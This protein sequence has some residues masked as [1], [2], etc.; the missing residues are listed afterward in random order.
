MMKNLLIQHGLILLL[1]FSGIASRPCL[2]A[3]EQTISLDAITELPTSLSAKA[4]ADRVFTWWLPE[5]FEVLT[6]P[7]SGGLQIDMKNDNATQWLRSQSHWDLKELPLLG[8]RYGT[9]TLAIFVPWPVYASLVTD[10]KV[11]IRFAF[12]I[13]RNNATPCQIIVQWT[14]NRP[15]AVANRFREW[16]AA[17]PDIGM[18]PRPKPLTVKAESTTAVNQLFG[19]VHF[20]LWGPAGFSRHDINR[21]NWI[22]FAKALLDAPP[23]TYG[24]RL[25]SSFTPEELKALSE[26]STAD[27]AMKYLTISVAGAIDR[28]LSNPQLVRTMDLRPRTV[29]RANQ[30]ELANAF[31]SLLRPAETWGDGLSTTLLD[32]LQ[33][34]GIKR[35]LLVLSDLYAASIRPDVVAQARKMGFPIGPYDSYHS[36]HS[37]EAA[38]DDTWSTAQFDASAYDQGRVV[39]ETGRHQGGF[40]GRGFHFAPEAAWPYVQRRVVALQANNNYSA[41]FIDCDATAE[42]FDDYNPRHLATRLD[43]IKHRR[44]RLAWL[45]K[46]QGLLVGSEGG[47]ILFADVIHFG[48][49]VHTPYIGHLAPSFRDQTSLHF[50]GRHWPPDSPDQSF[51]PVPLPSDL[52]SPYFDPQMRI[53]LYRA[54][55]GDE[56]VATHHWS[57]DSLKLIDVSSTRA[58]FEILYGVPPMYHLN[59]EMWPKRKDT[60]IHHLAFWAPL[61]KVIAPARLVR[62]EKLK[63]N[64]L[65]QRTSFQ[66]SEGI[67]TVTVNF[68]Q[69]MSAGFP[70]RSAR[71]TGIAALEGQI[72]RPN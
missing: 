8:A 65:V 16:R 10:Q 48:H 51:K 42:C 63:E 4:G 29:Y 23:D 39:K 14:D 58:L 46:D 17:A 15:L 61:H 35:A 11:G 57:F 54:A 36:V 6:L 7:V 70:G 9:Q 34:A 53:P 38:P 2:A 37:P 31:P 30:S 24:G 18:L 71:V 64:H 50:L 26:L 21:R 27:F 19:A 32:E 68:D 60:I 28:S 44:H 47:S 22:P 49:G 45:E 40:K 1:L 5:G 72:Y 12:P 25:R 59:R 56:I 43:D 55:L 67:V 41:W 3:N 33:E 52:N 62:F 69:A 20:Y 13:E 66:T